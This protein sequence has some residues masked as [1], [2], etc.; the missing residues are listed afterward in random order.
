MR[1]CH[2]VTLYVQYIA[3]LVLFNIEVFVMDMTC[4]QTRNK[5]FPQPDISSAFAVFKL[6]G[7]TDK[8]Y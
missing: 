5:I 2:D 7:F 8:L 4:R 3:C 6:L 1:M